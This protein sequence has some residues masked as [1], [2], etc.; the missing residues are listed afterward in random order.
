MTEREKIIYK[1]QPRLILLSIT[2]GGFVL[3]Q[4]LSIL[5]LKSSKNDFSYLPIS[6][7]ILFETLSLTALYY[8]LKIRTVQ[9]SEKALII[10]YLNLPI[11]EKFT[12][13]EIKSLHQTKE[14]VIINE[15]VFSKSG[16][17]FYHITTLILLKN[18]KMIKLYSIGEMDFQELIQTFQRL[19]R[20]EG[21][22]KV[23]KRHRFLYLLDN[24]HDV[25]M[26]IIFLFITIGLGCALLFG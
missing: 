9:L 18:D 4:L 17:N 8:F 21:K 12:F 1:T 22:I 7:I 2:L 10:S 16:Y 5:I 6:F 20:G 15:G 14:K 23:Q 24:L 26:T 19:R 13:E 3:S 11:R 25:F